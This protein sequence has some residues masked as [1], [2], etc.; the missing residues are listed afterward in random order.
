MAWWEIFLY[1]VN[2]FIWFC[3]GR[4]GHVYGGQIS[5]VPHHWIWGPLSIIVCIVLWFT[6]TAVNWI[7]FLLSAGAGLWVSDWI[8]FC[9]FRLFSPDDT[10]YPPVFWNID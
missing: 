2:L 8:D 9:N 4:L 5:W 3:V 7:P 10:T 1:V 6:A